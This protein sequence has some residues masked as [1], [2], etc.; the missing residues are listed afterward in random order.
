MTTYYMVEMHY[1]ATEDRAQFD[2]FYWKH[3]SMLLTID[4]FQSAQRYECT[5]E[6]RAPF[7]AV[8]KLRD[9]GVMESENYTS[10]AGRNSVN[11]T[12][13]AKMTN[14]DRNLVQGDIADMDVPE[15]G[16]MTLIDRLTPDS[17]PL[18]DGFTPLEIVGLDATIVQ[19]GVRIGAN[20]TPV[21]PNEG[22]AVRTLQ[23]IHHPRYPT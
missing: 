8:Y 20:D 2:E 1:P 3:I 14:W 15:G 16:S 9:P 10:K 18:P 5:H 11:P 19:R 23:P 7:L 4:G 6:A 22:W 12:F 17:T 21:E 13:R